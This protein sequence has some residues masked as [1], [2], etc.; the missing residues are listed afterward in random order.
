MNASLLEL[1]R[2]ELRSNGSALAAGLDRDGAD[3]SELKRAAHS[4]R[5]AAHIVG[6]DAV[7]ALAAAMEE[8]LAAAREAG[9]PAPG[10]RPALVEAIELLTAAAELRDEE[11]EGW[12]RERRET[13]DALSGRLRGRG[14]V[15]PARRSVTT[16]PRADGMMLELFRQETEVHAATLGQGLLAL[17]SDPG[18]FELLDSLM[19]AAHSI[20]GAARVVGL[21]AGVELAHAMEDAIV[22]AKRGQH[23]F[24]GDEIDLLLRA[25]DQLAQ[26]ATAAGARLDEFLAERGDELEALTE[27]VRRIRPGSVATETTGAAR[28]RAERAQP[29]RPKPEDREPGG[30]EVRDRVVRVTIDNVNRLMEL[31]GESVVETLRLAPLAASLQSVRAA[32][33]K[34]S[35]LLEELRLAASRTAGDPRALELAAAARDATAASRALLD[36]FGLQFEEY[37]RRVGSPEPAPLRR[38]DREPDAAVRRRAPRLAAAGARP[39]AE[40]RQAGRA[41][42]RR[43]DGVGVDRDILEKLEAPLNHLLRNAVDH[44]IESPAERAAA[45]K[46]ETATIRLEARHRAGMLTIAGRR[47][48]PRASTP[49]RFARRIVERGL[50]TRD[51]DAARLT[52]R[53][54]STSS[55]CPASRPR[56][57]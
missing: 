29:R 54:C 47:R 12:Q 5:G 30:R 36:G 45:G 49:R 9:K 46:P 11:V 57:R 33:R 22:A 10:A 42:D 24:G 13:L 7:E 55:S 32:H 21:D 18:H 27:D 52:T 53:S 20:K 56:P 48:R 2:E 25:T 4:I 34:V 23:S 3:W 41:R 17:E 40:A 44:G 38:G 39:G 6:L 16:G 31:S 15:R 50:A 43:R 28:A 8:S 51:G 26:L 1:F 14:A 35:D 19:R 37:A